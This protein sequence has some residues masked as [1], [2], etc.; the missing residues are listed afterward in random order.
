MTARSL[1]TIARSAKG[2]APDAV[3][4]DA[5][6][7]LQLAARRRGQQ[8]LLRDVSNEMRA[9][10]AFCGLREALGIEM[11]GQAEEGEERVRVEEER[12]LDD[13]AL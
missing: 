4:V 11:Q 9:L 3:S 5:L 13:P 6:A 8:I 1:G 2:L 12:Q 7:R 10:I